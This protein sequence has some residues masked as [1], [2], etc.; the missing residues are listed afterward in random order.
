M[1]VTDGS[2]TNSK[3]SNRNHK[4]LLCPAM[5][6]IQLL[7]QPISTSNNTPLL[8]RNILERPHKKIHTNI[9]DLDHIGC[10]TTKNTTKN[11]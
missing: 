4:E 9:M 11:T 7:N 8:K 5:I 10:D 2:P 1:L 6:F 3:H